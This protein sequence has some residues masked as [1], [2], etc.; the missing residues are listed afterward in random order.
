MLIDKLLVMS[1]DQAITSTAASTDTLDLQK[2]STSVNRLPVLVRGKNLLPTTATITVQLQESS[3]N[4]TWT[5]VETSRAYT[6]AELNS[7]LVGEVML[8]VKPKRYVRL[9]YVVASGPF[10]AGTVYAHIS[11]HRDVQ[12]AYPV[13]AGA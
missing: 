6:G 10:T 12:A 11:N 8:P 13:Y 1:M 2:A 9:N 7:G 4:S 3:D 5:T